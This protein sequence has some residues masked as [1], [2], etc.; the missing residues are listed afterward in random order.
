MKTNIK[1]TEYNHE[2]G[3]AASI[4]AEQQLRRSVLSCLL[5]EKEFYESGEDIVARIISLAG[6]VDKSIVHKL[7]IEART[8]YNLRHV[9]LMLLSAYPDATAIYNT[10]NRADEIAELL[11]MYW[12]DGKKPLPAQMKKGLAKA[13]T[14]FD[15][16]Q[17]AKYNRDGAVKLRD[18]LF[19]VHAKPKDDEQAAIW[20]LLVDGKLPAPDTWEVAL[21]SG[22]DKKATFERLIK[23]GQIGYLALLRNLRN[24]IEAGVD[25]NL[26]IDAIAARK[27]A[28]KVLPFRFIAAARYAPQFEPHLDQSMM[29]AIKALPRLTGRTVVLVDVSGSMDEKLSGK[30]DMTRIDAA[31]ALASIVSSDNLRVFSFSNNLVECPPRQGMAGVDAIKGS[32]PHGGTNLRAALMHLNDN[33]DY[34]RIIV[35][36]DEQS[37]DGSCDPKQGKIG[38][39][40]NVASNKNGVG[41]GRW[42]HIDGFSENVIRWINEQEK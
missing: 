29:Y 17:L 11:A 13:F 23:E 4:N 5:W 15:A 41:Y 30:S 2:S 14:K 9:P 12:R 6:Q 37:Q 18:A 34:D 33:I 25:A 40:I 28:E 35:I 16:Y 39:M 24:M 38:Y 22:A 32:Q 31:A 10:V 21:S 7:A 36:T 20:K 1:K 3:I 26:I 27:G 42:N 8:K 19:M